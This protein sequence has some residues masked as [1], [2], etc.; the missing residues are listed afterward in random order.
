MILNHITK[1]KNLPGIRSRGLVP[2][3]YPK[4]L[5]MSLG[6]EVVWLTSDDS[7]HGADDAAWIEARR[8]HIF[9]D[10]QA[11]DYLAECGVVPLGSVRLQIRLAP[12]SSRL[13]HYATW[14][15]KQPHPAALGL[16]SGLSPSARTHWHVYHGVILP[17]RIIDGLDKA[18]A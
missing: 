9:T 1:M 18:A 16:L 7:I 15:A 6:T 10:A 5:T 14:L 13:S 8:G 17:E 3:R 11:D 2:H 4:S 12:N